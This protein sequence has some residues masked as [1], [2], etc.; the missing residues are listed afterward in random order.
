MGITP[1]TL[2]APNGTEILFV[3][4]W[5]VL[6]SALIIE[7]SIKLVARTVVDYGLVD[8]EG[9]YPG[10]ERI[11]RETGLSERSVREAWHFMRGAEMAIR[12]I[13][14]AWTGRYRTADTWQL[15]IPDYWR[16]LPMLGPNSGR[17]T[18]QQCGK[19]FN[20]Q[21]CN[22]FAT[23]AKGRPVIDPETGD[24]QVRWQLYKAVFCNPPRRGP[25]CWDK[26]Q[27]ANAGQWTD[28]AWDLFR[29]ARNDDWLSTGY[30]N[31]LPVPELSSANT[32]K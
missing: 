2:T 17:F 11:A 25:S 10:N 30:R 14:S 27:R 15:L 16:N 32:R 18:C 9:V 20:P 5:N 6:V 23:D 8:G 4:R 3:R 24:R 26:W 7:P 28:A 31:S 19:L 13:R 1:D 22:V 21:P 29:K 12:D